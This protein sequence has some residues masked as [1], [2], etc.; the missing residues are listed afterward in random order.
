MYYV[1]MYVFIYCLFKGVISPS[2]YRPIA[3]SGKIITGR[4]CKTELSGGMI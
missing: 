1:F 2:E 4:M 3:T